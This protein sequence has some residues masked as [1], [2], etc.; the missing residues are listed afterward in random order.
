MLLAG[1]L[2]KLFADRQVDVDPAVIQYVVKRMER[3][4]ESAN[5]VVER[6]DAAA[7]A[8]KSRITRAL[9]AELLEER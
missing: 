7:L 3:S 1:V 6:L 4:F 8:R 9:A 5:A 2:T